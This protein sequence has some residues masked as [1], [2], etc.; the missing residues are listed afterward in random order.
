M[1]E[2]LDR[3]GYIYVYVHI[4]ITGTD[5]WVYSIDSITKNEQCPFKYH[6]MLC[7]TWT[8]STVFN[9]IYEI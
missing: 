3:Y 6:F 7:H 9:S 1:T 8:Q 2:D 4:Y 5:N